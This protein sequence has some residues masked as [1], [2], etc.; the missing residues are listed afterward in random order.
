M[1]NTFYKFKSE[2]TYI[3][4]HK[5]MRIIHDFTKINKNIKISQYLT[6]THLPGAGE[7]LR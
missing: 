4:R 7:T 2:A 5:M 1:K 3:H 6:I